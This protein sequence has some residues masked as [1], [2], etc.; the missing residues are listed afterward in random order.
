MM[1]T[2]YH[3]KEFIGFKTVKSAVKPF[4]DRRKTPLRQEYCHSDINF[5]MN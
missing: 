3:L 2:L 1:V 4:V 5:L